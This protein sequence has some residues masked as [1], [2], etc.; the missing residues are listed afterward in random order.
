M[1]RTISAHV[2]GGQSGG[3]IACADPGAMTPIVVSRIALL[4]IL[5]G[6][7]VST[8]HILTYKIFKFYLFIIL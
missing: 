1:R 7:M 4:V 5:N 8:N 6:G 3:S 2:D